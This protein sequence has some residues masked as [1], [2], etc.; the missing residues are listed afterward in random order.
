MYDNFNNKDP[1]LYI[2]LYD[3]TQPDEHPPVI[4]TVSVAYTTP[5]NTL[6]VDSSLLLNT[7]VD[8]DDE[9]IIPQLDG[10][11]DIALS[12]GPSSIPHRVFSVP[13]GASIDQAQYRLNPKKQLKKL[14]QD[15]F[16]KDFDITVSPAEH[17]VSIICSTGFYS[18]VAIPAF[19]QTTIGTTNTVGN[20]MVHCYDISGKVDDVGSTVNA[21]IFYRFTRKSDKTSAGGVTIHLHHTARRVQIQGNTMVTSNSRAG[22]WFVQ[23]FLL[24]R[25]KVEA[26]SKSFD[27]ERFNSAVSNIVTSHVEKLSNMEKCEGCTGHFT[28]RSV[29]EQC[30]ICLKKYHKKC[31]QTDVHP[32]MVPPTSLSYPVSTTPVPTNTR[33]AI[34][35]SVTQS[36]NT[37]T[38]ACL[39]T[40]T[41][42]CSS[43][44]TSHGSTPLVSSRCLVTV[45]PPSLPPDIR[46]T[47]ANSVSAVQPGPSI[48][49]QSATPSVSHC[50]S[51]VFPI[52][53]ITYTSG[54]SGSNSLSCVQSSTS[55][56]T[57]P[58]YPVSTTAVQTAGRPP[59]VP[60]QV[61]GLSNPPPGPS[62]V[63]YSQPKTG[64]AKSKQSNIATTK[65]G[66]ALEY[67]RIEVN[68]IKARIKAL[69]TKN[70]DLEYQNSLLLERLSILDKA[71]KDFIYDKYFPK[72][73]VASSDKNT[74]NLSS[75]K[76]HH[77]HCCAHRYHC[78]QEVPGLQP[79]VSLQRGE[80]F[81][82][83]VI[84]I[85][86]IKADLVILKAKLEKMEVTCP[87]STYRDDIQEPKEQESNE[88]NNIN[89]DNSVVT[90]DEN[91]GDID[92][93][94]FSLNF[95]AQTSQLL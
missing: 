68:T 77:S 79:S 14:K 27:I 86:D 19:A 61:S 80:A 53:S 70:K 11:D 49:V 66:I 9:N 81:N 20:I 82:T 71:E 64:K 67:S 5:S 85:D 54:I 45:V 2:P 74:T 56:S 44:T 52:Q 87:A 94:T 35:V 31:I 41:T 39:V 93:E 75:S 57:I 92:D 16:L 78:C 69:E 12:P 46:Q 6:Q 63:N 24:D 32:C 34:A 13:D 47:T 23:N 55:I 15:S 83:L 30:R 51:F 48:T 37:R 22:V 95:H 76:F 90:V 8:V 36:C 89:S 1:V 65:D 88:N 50:S 62:N 60:Q 91:V 21:R 84:G 26:Q 7:L 33:Q 17:S 25:F 3:L 72:P 18:L 29:P 42:T 10:T 58:T 43:F 40:S 38:S 28:G 59:P 4:Q 73:G